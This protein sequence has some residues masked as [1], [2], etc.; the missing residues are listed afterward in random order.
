MSGTCHHHH[1][2]AGAGAHSRDY[3][4]AL[5]IV[6]AI[7]AG[8][9][10]VEAT[11]G[12]IGGSV[13]LQAD[14]L[15]FLGDAATY[16]VSLA[17]LGLALRWRARAALL[18]GATMGL[19]G[20]WVLG[21][22]VAHAM[23]GHVPSAPLMGGIGMAA[24]AANVASAM[25]LFRHRGGD[26]NRRS[27]WLCTRNDAIG[28]IAVVAAGALV[29]VLGSGWPDL[30]VGGAMGLLALHSAATVVGQARRELRSAA[31]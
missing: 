17:V 6:L 2:E 5:W 28:N 22:A 19:F 7:N 29:F 11:F 8:M 4:R 25:V 15:D 18:K 23:A 27:V 10:L 1:D 21:N 9:F 3:R 30:V 14:A 16:G 12:V 26:S 31:A 13:A 24:L 20:F